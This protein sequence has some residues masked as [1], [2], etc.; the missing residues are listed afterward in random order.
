MLLTHHQP[1]SAFSEEDSGEKLRARVRPFLAA[2]KI[3]GWI[4][5][6]EHLCIKYGL[7]EGIKGRCIGHGCI[8]YDLP[9]K[10]SGRAPVEWI[11]RREQATSDNRGMHGF[12]LLRVDGPNMRIEYID[13]DG[14]IA[15]TEDY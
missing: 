14:V 7:H 2:K 3:Y 9:G 6:H 11:N 8:P 13:Q 10:P 15:H 1:F 4:W 12:A 5:G